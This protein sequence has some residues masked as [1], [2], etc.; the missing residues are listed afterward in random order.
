MKS[1]NAYSAVI[2]KTKERFNQKILRIMQTMFICNFVLFLNFVISFV[3]IALPNYTNAGILSGIPE[4]SKKMHALRGFP[5]VSSK[6]LFSANEVNV[7]VCSVS[8]RSL[9]I[10]FS[11]SNNGHS[12]LQRLCDFTFRAFALRLCFIYLINLFCPSKTDFCTEKI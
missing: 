3:R 9:S 7:G 10:E 12:L 2:V 5:P 6:T 1:R 4:I 11:S 8:T